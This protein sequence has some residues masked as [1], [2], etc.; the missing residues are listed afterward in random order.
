MEKGVHKYKTKKKPHTP[1]VPKQKPSETQDRPENKEE[2]PS[3]GRP[4]PSL[5]ST[6]D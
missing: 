4:D 1:S 5:K 6:L 3:T 2:K